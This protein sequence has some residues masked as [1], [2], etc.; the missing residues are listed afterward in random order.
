VGDLNGELL[1]DLAVARAEIAERLSEVGRVVAVTSG[2]GGVGK[3]AVA[4]NL[5]VALAQRGE[6]VGLLDADL[7]S[8]SVAAMLGLRGR[9]VRMRGGELLPQE[10]VL[11]L[12]VQGFD[13]FLQSGQA[14]DWDGPAGEGAPLRSALEDAALAD[15]LGQ[16]AWGPLR[17]LV[18]DLAPG[19]DRLT[20]LARLLPERLCALA[21]TI[22]TQVSLLAVLRS[23]RRAHD[24]RVPVIGLVENMTSAV[25]A[26]CGCEAPLFHE[27]D[28]ARAAGDL[29]LPLVARIPFEP[30]LAAAGDAG[31]P[32]ALGAGAGTLAAQRFAAL[33]AE[34]DRY[35]APDAGGDR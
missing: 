10:A 27:V 34:V 30:R 7:N 3:T 23:V 31:E 28:V 13:F 21:V 2:K 6:R 9:P 11:G 5:A 12:R 19:A 4:V 24:A 20:A 33:A 25:C 14:L 35:V 18:V 17:T 29:A 22:P 26:A 15:L 16:T 8:P 1:R 32:L